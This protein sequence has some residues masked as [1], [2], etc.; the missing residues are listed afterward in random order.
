MEGTRDAIC[1]PPSERLASGAEVRPV[2]AILCPAGWGIRN[3]LHSG[4]TTHLQARGIG[5]VVLTVKEYLHDAQRDWSAAARGLELLDAPVIGSQRG[6]AALNGLLR[7]SF[8]R[9]HRISTYRI[10]NRLRRQ[11]EGARPGVRNAVLEALSLLGSRDPFYGWQVRAAEALFR[12]SRDLGP[13]TRQLQETEATL[14]VSTNCQIS[15]ELPYVLA[16][17]DLGIPTLGCIQSFDN[18]TSRSVLPV[19]D[20]YALWNQ[21]MKD[22]LLAYYPDRHPDTAH[23]T[24]T[25]QFDFH[26]RSDCRWTREATLQRL[27]LRVNDRYILWAANHYAATPDE[28]ERVDALARQCATTPELRNHRIVVRLHPLDDRRRWERGPSDP[29]VVASWPWEGTAGMPHPLDQARL[30]STLVHADVCLNTASTMSLDAAVVGTPVVCVAF[31]DPGGHYTEHFR[32]IAESGGVRMAFDLRQLVSYVVAYIRD[33]SRDE[34][35]RR[36]LVARECGPVDGGSAARVAT[37]IAGIV[38]AP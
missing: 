37:L 9:R 24:G 26:V 36:R 2:V 10:L 38:G 1:R 22:Q 29:R 23:I 21:R 30:V 34:A 20:H 15:D 27:G 17:R 35:E 11:N 28:P 18:F 12:R 33:R 6:H 19:F 32:P 13:A 5:T 4:L 25:P 3:I 31:G 8:A 16:A 7:A 14:V